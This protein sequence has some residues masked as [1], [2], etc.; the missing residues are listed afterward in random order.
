MG[1]NMKTQI[2]RSQQKNSEKS[3]CQY[4][5]LRKMGEELLL[6]HPDAATE[7]AVVVHA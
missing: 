1:Y 3:L 4:L 5:S 2:S 6:E 7:P